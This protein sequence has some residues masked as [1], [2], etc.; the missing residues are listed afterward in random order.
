MMDKSKSAENANTTSE[1]ERRNEGGREFGHVHQPTQAQQASKNRGLADDA[2]GRESELK[3]A[4]EGEK[5]T[6]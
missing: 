4:R 5:K 2:A 6:A 1:H 3:R